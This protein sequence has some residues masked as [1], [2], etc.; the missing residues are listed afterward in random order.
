VKQFWVWL[1]LAAAS[2]AQTPPRRILYVTHSAGFR[3]G[4]IEVSRR[5]LDQV[6]ARSGRFAVTATE[7]LSLITASSLSGYDAVFFFTS[8]ELALGAGQRAAL[9]DFVSGGKGFGGAH[10]ATDTLYDWPEYGELIGGYFDGHPWTQEVA[11]DIEDP[12]HPATRGSPNSFRILD[13]IYQHRNFSRDRVRVLMT[14][15]VGSV[16]V[17]VSGVNRT[18]GDFALAWCRDYGRGRVFYTAL[19]HFDETWLDPRFQNQLEGALL[20][21]VGEAPGN[22]S[23]RGGSAEPVPVIAR[24]AVVNAASFQAAPENLL[25]PGTLISIFGERLTTGSTMTAAAFPLPAKLAGTTVLVNGRPAPLLFA[26][27]RQINVQLPFDL[28]P[29]EPVRISVRS[30][31]QSSGEEAARVEASSPGIFAV[32]GDGR[33]PGDT[34]AIYGTGLGAVRPPV[35]PGVAA[36][37]VPL[38]ETLVAPVVTIGGLR[39]EVP[40]SGL[41]PGFAG[42]YQVNAIVP[43]GLAAGPAAVRIEAGGRRSNEVSVRLAP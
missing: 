12:D 6:A 40:Y 3:H 9:L 34:I 19:G 36:P 25:A 2:I 31:F 10:S 42:L 8:G 32:D 18:D 5:V 33:R 14:L 27:P 20:W 4:S 17:N 35:P 38:S 22:A 24:G 26:S 7:D 13:E 41:A 30:V 1:A 39:S 43:P 15:D 16:P 21:L 11:I 28:G 37:A 23:P 29:G